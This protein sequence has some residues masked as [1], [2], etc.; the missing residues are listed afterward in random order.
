MN[1]PEKFY[2]EQKNIAEK[3]VAE[4][5]KK[6]TLLSWARGLSFVIGVVA[7][8]FS[9]A[10]FTIA[11]SILVLVVSFAFLIYFI[12]FYLK[13]NEELKH[14]KRIILINENELKAL[15]YDFSVFHSGDEFQKAAHDFSFDLDLFGENS[16]YQMINR[17]NTDFGKNKVAGYFENPLRDSNK[18]IEIQ[19]AVSELNLLNKWQQT[20]SA[21]AMNANEEIKKTSYNLLTFREKTENKSVDISDLKLAS[22][23]GDVFS[24]NFW[25]LILIVLP[26]IVI[27]SLVLGVLGIVPDSVVLLLSIFSLMVVGSKLKYIN[28][29]H[30][31]VSKQSKIFKR[32]SV[33]LEMIEKEDFK[34]ELLVQ[35]QQKLEVEQKKSSEV[36]REF[37]KLLNSLDSRLNMLFGVISN[38]IVLWDIQVV[39]RIEIW[40]KKYSHNFDTWFDVIAEFEFLIS[41]SAF[42][43]NNPEFK[44]PKVSNEFA[45]SATE[46]GHPSIPK[47]QRVCS[48]FAISEKTKTFIVTGANMAGKSTF[49]RTIGVNFILAQIGSVVCANEMIFSP[50]CILTSIR[51][52]DSLSSNESYFYAEL[53]RLKYIVELVESGEEALVII[54][55]MLRGTNSDDK[56]SGSEGLLR[57][58]TKRNVITFLATHD[59]ALGKL[60]DEFPDEVRNYCFEAEIKDDELFF[61]Y[62]LK[63]GV[64]KNLNA[65]F[66]MKKMKII[67]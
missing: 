55:E 58:L 8:Y 29:V 49:L 56:H 5:K 20:F 41:L 51:I 35:L 61:D 1:N 36:L 13:C 62:K 40:N 34:S 59:V 30:N 3:K 48:D 22:N 24:S 26:S 64:S 57:K 28:S 14:F 16:V 63:K 15:G 50:I 7:T 6:I 46:L 60:E 32:Y 65:S 43:Y 47:Q 4:L 66:L 42:A 9:F 12:K 31:K 38:S 21:N 33:L 19:N 67:G 27:L 54:D 18:I 10:N 25:K 44:F 53:K 11:I 23:I 2:L 17:A 45:F 52:T 37:S 39:R